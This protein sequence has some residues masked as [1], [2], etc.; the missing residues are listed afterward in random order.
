MSSF[1]ELYAQDSGTSPLS[2]VVERLATAS[3]SDTSEVD[4]ASY[5]DLVS[6]WNDWKHL[7]ERGRHWSSVLAK[8]VLAPEETR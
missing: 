6:P 2:E 8:L 1:D 7:S 5:K 3:P 4:L